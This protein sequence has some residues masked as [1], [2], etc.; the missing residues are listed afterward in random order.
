MSAKLELSPRFTDQTG[1]GLENSVPSGVGPAPSPVI[2]TRRADVCVRGD[3]N[4]G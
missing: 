3:L 2:M 1:L 4:D